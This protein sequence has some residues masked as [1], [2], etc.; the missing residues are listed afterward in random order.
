MVVGQEPSE[1]SLDV[2]ANGVEKRLREIY[3]NYA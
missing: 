1:D 3:T 2:C